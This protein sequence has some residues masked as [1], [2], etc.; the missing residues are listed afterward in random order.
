MRGEAFGGSENAM[1][2]TRRVRTLLLHTEVPQK[3]Q[4]GDHRV[5]IA[6]H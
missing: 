4:V 6:P 3:E 1:S 5:D 2:N